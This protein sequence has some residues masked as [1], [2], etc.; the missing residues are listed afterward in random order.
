MGV[1]N[2]ARRAAKQ[3]KR[4][5]GRRPPGWGAGAHGRPTGQRRDELLNE[6][7]VGTATAAAVFEALA[8]VTADRSAAARRARLL[9]GPDSPVPPALVVEFLADILGDSVAAVVH[10]GWLPSDLVEIVRRQLS[11]AHLPTLAASLWAEVRRHHGQPVDRAWLDELYQLGPEE[12]AAPTSTGLELVLG[13]C[14]LLSTLPAVAQVHPPPG[15][16]RRGWSAAGGTD[17]KV[18]TR[19]RALLAKAES[20]QFSEEA[21][22]LSAKAQELISRY[23]LDRLLDETDLPR[24]TN[25][26]TVRRL[27]LDP[28]YVVAKASLVNAVADANRCRAVLTEELGFVT[29]VG[30]PRDVE[31]VDLLTTSLLV[32]ANAAMLRC[33]R[34][35]DRRGTSRTRSFRSSFL[36]A[37]AARIRQRLHAAA[38]DAAVATGR[39][40]ELVPV[41][42]QRAEA[43]SA[44]T[45][46]LFPRLVQRES[47]IANGAGWAAGMAAADLARLD[48]FLAVTEAAS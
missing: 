6:G 8:E 24:H 14:A 47:T 46:E 42:K 10:S 37:Y 34:Q 11:P 5:N 19:V 29:V 16:Q 40:G 25:Q 27:W 4:A 30:E 41:L 7:L 18:L 35:S 9:T 13:L 31:A 20:T 38:Q 28:P 3:R 12:A 26:L 39:G 36:T 21:E 22:A 23:A 1:H 43:V 15:E 44:A 33:G 48:S 45:E 2:R 17:T 32:Q